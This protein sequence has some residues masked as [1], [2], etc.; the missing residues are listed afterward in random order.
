MHFARTGALIVAIPFYDAEHT[1]ARHGIDLGRVTMTYYEA[2]HM[3]YL[4]DPSCRSVA[5]DA[6]D[7]LTSVLDGR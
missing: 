3:M 7:F 6:H 5:A 4:H 2:G 1:F